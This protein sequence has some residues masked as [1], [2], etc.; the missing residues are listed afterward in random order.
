MRRTD[1]ILRWLEQVPIEQVCC[2]LSLVA[3]HFGIALDDCS[4]AVQ[5]AGPYVHGRSINEI[6]R[7]EPR[8]ITGG[9]RMWDAASEQWATFSV[10]NDCEM[11]RAGFTFEVRLRRDC[12]L[13]PT[14]LQEPQIPSAR[15]LVEFAQYAAQASSAHVVY[16]LDVGAYKACFSHPNPK[17]EAVVVWL[18]RGGL[19]KL[20][21]LHDYGGEPF[22]G[23]PD[24]GGGYVFRDRAGKV[25]AFEALDSNDCL[26]L[27]NRC[28]VA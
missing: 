4:F 20:P 26:L 7:Q 8:I 23:S 11:P 24:Y 10:L 13:Y 1:I 27:T 5:E 12:T 2:E 15:E 9:G 14:F 18:A 6:V 22:Q 17:D 21:R 25:L 28:K 3:G 16:G 19:S